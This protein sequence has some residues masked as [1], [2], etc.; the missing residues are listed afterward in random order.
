MPELE[1]AL[2][3]RSAIA[4]PQP[5]ITTTRPTTAAMMS[6]HGVRWTATGGAAA[7]GV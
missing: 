6:I 3:P 7:A 1:L 4:V 2:L 5:A